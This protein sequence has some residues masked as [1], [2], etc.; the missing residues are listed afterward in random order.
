M[1]IFTCMSSNEGVKAFAQSPE[2]SAPK[3]RTTDQVFFKTV[4]RAVKLTALFLLIGF[5][6]LSA[7]TTAQQRISINMKAA[8]LD[9]I[10]AEIEKRSGYTVFYN[11]DVLK[12]AGLV[13]IDM[14][15]ASIEDVLHQCLKG[16]PLE[17]TIQEK[18]IFVKKE[19]RRISIDQSAGPGD[20]P[21]VSGIVRSESGA[22]LAGATVAIR[23]IKRQILTNAAG[24]FILKGVADGEYEMDVSFVGY[25]NYSRSINVE[26]HEAHVEVSLKQSMDQLD[27][28]VVKGYYTTTNRLNTGDVTTVKGEDIAKQP[29]SDPMLALEGRVPGLFIQQ[30]SGVPGS[31]NTIRIR[32]QN[33]IANGN[34]PLYIV[35]GVPY[36]ATSPTSTY[37]GGGILGNPGSASYS[38]ASPFNDLSPSD[39]ESIEVLKDADATAIYGS[40]GAN[41]VI[42]ITTK[43]G[44]AGSTKFDLNAFS[45]F[46]KTTRFLPLLSTPQYLEMR[47]EAFNNDGLSPDPTYD[48]D[49]TAWDTSRYTNWQKILIGK[50]SQF[51]N[52]QGV[53]SGGNSYTQF[54]ISGAYGY[55]GVD[56][57]GNYADQKA[58]VSF[59]LNHASL[60]Q[61]LHVQLAANYIYDYSNLPIS[62]PTGTITLA[63]DAPP[64]YD[65]NG[66]LN[67][68]PVN[69]DASWT[70]PLSYT[71]QHANA[72][73]DNL[74]AN[75]M[76]NY[77]L[78][79]GLELK[80]SFGYGHLQ[81]NQ[82]QLTPANLYAP[83]YDN[84]P[85]DRMNLYAMN[86]SRSW[87]I[88]PQIIYG[89]DILKGKFNFLLGGTFQQNTSN[90]NGF[91]SS[92]F[93]SD[94][95]LNDPAA[96]ASTTLIGFSSTTYHYDAIFARIGYD[97]EEKYLLNITARR[98][99]S[100]RFGPGKQFGNFGAIDRK[101]VV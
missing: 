7:R 67:W 14:K 60:D 64:L 94:A 31:Y 53:I 99:G 83:P 46:G 77:Q 47:H 49:M 10:F 42:L 24:E 37:I 59:S 45:G 101:S 84:L 48:F 69:G 92:G 62:N 18:T 75:F 22:A 2:V 63:P 8:P 3:P 74:L 93:A 4:V 38:G 25:Q 61:K 100:S 72:K 32:G 21:G 51:S 98:D 13:T 1:Y 71:L 55:Q 5:I 79:P 19:V 87:I 12:T 68:Q 6:H 23:K 40:R 89:R 86:E 16:L 36:S 73:T 41:G 52:L 58:V 50:A 35:D 44:K 65:G 90:S 9:K 78:F 34:N 54:R 80:S 81:N 30:S 20:P 97:W 82:T 66:N 39:I 96:A 70:N 88:E 27:E 56:F 17:F 57:P 85:G 29:V 11:T 26:N 33:S 91:I 95:L 43:K 28:T 15:D 76:I